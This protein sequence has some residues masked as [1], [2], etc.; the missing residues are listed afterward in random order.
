MLEI[1]LVGILNS[2]V[3]LIFFLKLWWKDMCSNFRVWGNYEKVVY[4]IYFGNG[5]C[6]YVK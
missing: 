5:F 6:F 1:N 3:N 4:Y 2:D